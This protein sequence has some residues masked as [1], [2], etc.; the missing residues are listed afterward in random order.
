MRMG[1]FNK[2]EHQRQVQPDARSVHPIW[3][4]IGC[5]LLILIP[6]LSYAGADLL[7]NENLNQHWVP[8][9]VV[10]LQ[11]VEVPV[12]G[13]AVPHL[14]ANLLVA[15]LLALIGF[16]A[17]TMIYSVMYSA[18]APSRYGPLDAPPD[19]FRPRKRRR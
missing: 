11:T 3:Q 2:Y 16:A 14:Y 10:L 15:L 6:I 17:V 1:R 18:M 19:E 12:V 7:V 5:L 4:G 8:A 9:P 13:I